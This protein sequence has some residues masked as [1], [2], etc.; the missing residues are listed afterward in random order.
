MNRTRA[1]LVALVM[2][3]AGTV[4]PVGAGQAVASQQAV[5]PLTQEQAVQRV[6]QL[7]PE[8]QAL[9]KVEGTETELEWGTPPGWFFEIGDEVSA[10]LVNV[11]VAKTG[12]L[13][14]YEDLRADE[15]DAVVPEQVE[16]LA[17]QMLQ[18]LAPDRAERMRANGSWHEELGD[19][20]YQYSAIELVNG[21]EFWRNSLTLEFEASGTLRRFGRGGNYDSHRLPPAFLAQTPEQVL[22][23]VRELLQP[24]PVYLPVATSGQGTVEL[25]LAYAFPHWV[26][27]DAISGKPTQS[28]WGGPQLTSTHVV[29]GQLQ[30]PADGDVA[31]AERLFKR[32]IGRHD[33]VLKQQVQDDLLEKDDVLPGFWWDVTVDGS[34][35]PVGLYQDKGKMHVYQ[36]VDMAQQP[37]QPTRPLSDQQALQKALAIAAEL[38][39][40][41]QHEL[42]RVVKDAG[43]QQV[44]DWY[45][46]EPQLEGDLP[47]ADDEVLNFEFISTHNGI[48]VPSHA[49]S[50][51]L[52]RSGLVRWASASVRQPVT[53]RATGTPLTA[54][55]AVEQVLAEPLQLSYNWETYYEQ[56][57]PYGLLVYHTTPIRYL[58][59]WTGKPVQLPEDA[60][61]SF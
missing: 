41:G 40:S 17:P 27:L 24:L 21:L 59:A 36:A 9:P 56:Q 33:A 52:T 45:I 55:Q 44:P 58:D 51:S 29:Q 54:E 28:S 10:G 46:V 18:K 1:A 26:E 14:Y 11:H 60:D 3:M 16:A 8:L 30:W 19:V 2:T 6:Y 43:S 34:T 32:I 22:P 20:T 42:V 35:Y 5:Q 39:P 50:V 7:F 37:T 15:L 13:L 4:M 25:G 47:D 38:L 61:F 31:A 23:R 53:F 57:A 49:Y 12:E 48:P